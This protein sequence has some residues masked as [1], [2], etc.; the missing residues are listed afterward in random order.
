MMMMMYCHAN[1]QMGFFARLGATIET[2]KSI[3]C[4]SEKV[5]HARFK[6]TKSMWQCGSKLNLTLHYS[7]VIIPHLMRPLATADLTF[8]I[9]FAGEADRNADA[10]G[11]QH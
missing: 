8:Q 2:D 3:S 10:I 4:P 11:T 6:S 5:Q 7:A 9:C 1:F